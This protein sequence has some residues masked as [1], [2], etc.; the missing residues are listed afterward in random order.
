MHATSISDSGSAD[1]FRTIAELGGD[2][3]WVIDCGS[4]RLHYISACVEQLLGYAVADFHAQ[5]GAAQFFNALPDPS[6]APLAALCAGVPARLA[7][8]AGGDQSR[9][10]LVRQFD[11]RHSDGHT[12]P[13]E[14][15][16]C[17]LVDVAGRAVSLVGIVRDLAAQRARAVGQHRF[18]SMLNHEFRTPLSNIDGAIQRLEAGSAGADAP[19]RARYRRI[20][21][22]VERMVGLLDTHLSPERLD[23][24]GVVRPAERI[25]PRQLLEEGAAL[26]RAAGRSVTVTT[27]GLPDTLRCAPQGLRMALQVL[28]TNA[29]QYGPAAAPI[30]LSGRR[31]DGGIALLVRDHGAGVPLEDIAH[32]FAKSARGG[33]AGALPGSG[34]GLYMAR[35]VVEVHGGTL[36]VCNVVPSGAEFCLWLPLR[37]AAGKPVASIWPSRDNSVR[38]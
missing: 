9:L 36:G 38:N 12:V 32:I 3:A 5:L 17:V 4:G 14:V 20:A 33:N 10:R 13:L 37:E 21:D 11:V 27:S 22:A 19:T 31:L 24:A 28:V 8:L 1:Q 30:A 2:V 16:S 6:C 34:L 29:L 26:V 23:A 18:V 35:A 15:V 25:D 7:R